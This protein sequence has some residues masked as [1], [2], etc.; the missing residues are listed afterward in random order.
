M[1]TT[2]SITRISR[3]TAS[4]ATRRALR[5]SRQP[6]PARRAASTPAARTRPTPIRIAIACSWRRSSS[7]GPRP[8]GPMPSYLPAEGSSARRARQSELDQ[9][10]GQIHDVAG[11]GR[12]DM[13]PGFPAVGRPADPTRR[14]LRREEPR[15][16]GRA[17]TD[18][19]WID[20]NAPVLDHPVRPQVQDARGAARPRPGQSRQPQRGRQRPRQRPTNLHA[21]N[22]G[23]GQWEVNMSQCAQQHQ[24]PQRVDEPFP[25]Q[26]RPRRPLRQQPDRSAVERVPSERPDAARLR[27]G[28]PQR[29]RRSKPAARRLR[30]TNGPL[31]AAGPGGHGPVPVLSHLPDR[32]RQR[33]APGD[34]HEWFTA[35]DRPV[36]PP[37]VLQPPLP[38]QPQPAAVAVEPRRPDVRR[39]GRLAQLRSRCSCPA[40]TSKP[41]RPHRHDPAHQRDDA[42]EHG[43]R[44]ARRRA[45]HLGSHDQ[46]R[47][48]YHL[49]P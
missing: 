45:L 33:R 23:W 34:D 41:G 11:Y 7:P 28:R 42:A 29:P 15:S 19:P 27:P 17:A 8:D 31:Y 1:I 35:A 10:S 32:L 6:Q 14:R 37:D 36:V 13:G 18:S 43:P 25:R 30:R 26:R 21:G 5:H 46:R 20:V 38:Q 2:S 47:L 16:A 3:P 49:Q 4:S 44:P 24:R 40:T 39:T 22:Q 48:Q 12:Q 9:R